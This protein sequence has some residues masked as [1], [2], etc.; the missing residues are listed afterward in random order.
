ML[1]LSRNAGESDILAEFIDE[2][3]LVLFEVLEDGLHGGVVVRNGWCVERNVTW[4]KLFLPGTEEVV[5]EVVER[6]L[7]VGGLIG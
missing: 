3:G 2:A 6:S 7:V 5:Q 4:L 1:R